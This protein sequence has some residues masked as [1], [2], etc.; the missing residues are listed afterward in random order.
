M[1]PIK[2]PPGARKRGGGSVIL[3]VT[4]VSPRLNQVRKEVGIV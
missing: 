3:S 4:A 1:E 2:C